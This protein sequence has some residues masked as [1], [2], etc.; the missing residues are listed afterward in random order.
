MTIDKAYSRRE[1][2]TMN[3]KDVKPNDVK[4]RKARNSPLTK[5]Q[6]CAQV[7]RVLERVAPEGRKDVLQAAMLMM[8]IDEAPPNP[9][10]RF[11]AT[12]GSGRFA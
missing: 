2:H 5:A 12:L 11:P 7:L 10:D 4:A 9:S 3:D 1:S 8:P 6:A